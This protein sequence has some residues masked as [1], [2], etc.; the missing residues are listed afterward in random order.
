[1]IAVQEERVSLFKKQPSPA[2]IQNMGRGACGRYNK[3]RKLIKRFMHTINRSND[4]SHLTLKT[5][6]AE[7]VTKIE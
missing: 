7:T 5:T 4:L 6:W 3:E 2:W 1:M